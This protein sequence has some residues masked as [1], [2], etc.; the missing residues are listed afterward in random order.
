VSGGILAAKTNARVVGD[1]LNILF[2]ALKTLVFNCSTG[3][4][5]ERFEH[6]E[7]HCQFFKVLKMNSLT[8]YRNQFPTKRCST[9]EQ[10]IEHFYSVCHWNKLTFLAIAAAANLL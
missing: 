6:F 4:E 9:P 8:F 10:Q 7:H 2:L 5:I 3:L 1:H